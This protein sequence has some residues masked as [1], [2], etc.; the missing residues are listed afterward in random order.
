MRKFGKGKKFTKG[1][2]A[3]LAGAMVFAFSPVT[4]FATVGP[5]APRRG[6]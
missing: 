2:T 3:L 4:A 1:A 6:E 5:K